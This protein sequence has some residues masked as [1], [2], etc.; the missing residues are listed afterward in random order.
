MHPNQV[1]GRVWVR[2]QWESRI[3]R[4]LAG[5]IGDVDKDVDVQQE[6]VGEIFAVVDD[7]EARES[8]AQ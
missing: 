5:G 1:R 2:A 8:I 4:G 3:E 7:V 6:V